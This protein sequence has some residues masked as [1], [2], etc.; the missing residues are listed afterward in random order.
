MFMSQQDAVV[1]YREQE[2]WSGDVEVELSNKAFD[3]V[4]GPLGS[5]AKKYEEGQPVVTIRKV[6]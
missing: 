3:S 2:T 1:I 4:V 6:G 5:K